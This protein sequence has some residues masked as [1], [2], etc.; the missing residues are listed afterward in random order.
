MSDGKYQEIRTDG[1]PMVDPQ[2]AVRTLRDKVRSGL[3]DVL[4]Q[5]YKP[6][7]LRIGVTVSPKINV[8]MARAANEL[9][10]EVL[11]QLRRS[12]PRAEAYPYA[13]PRD[14]GALDVGV[15]IGFQG[16]FPGPDGWID[17]RQAR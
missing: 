5:P 17:R 7:T 6:A 11:P 15:A 1:M 14:D 9:V 4:A 16:Q 2:V 3:N 12:F 8:D 13:D 10:L